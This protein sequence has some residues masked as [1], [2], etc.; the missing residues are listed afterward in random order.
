MTPQVLET[1]CEWRAEDVADPPPGPN[2]LSAAEI[3]EIEAAIA[4]AR[5]KSD[6]LLDIGKADFPAADLG[7]APEGHRARA[8]GRARLRADPRPAA[9]A[10]VQRRDVPGLLGHRRAP[11]PALA[12]EPQRPSAGRRHRPGQ[13]CRTIPPRAAT[14]SARSA[15]SS[16]ATAPTSS[17]CCAW[18]R[19]V[20]RRPV[21]GVPIRW[22][23][24][25]TWCASGRTWPPSST[26]PSPTTC[27]A[28][29][30]P[31]TRGWYELPVFTDLDGRLF[32]RLIGA[33]ILRLAAPRR[34]RRG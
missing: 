6:D 12:A 10:L 28:N 13:G 4:H 30:R 21:G 32:V 3:A 24:T 25:T 20:T 33:Y 34:T 9:R 8:D 31:G 27:A 23:C 22:P 5:A 11:G 1:A 2:M 19:G 18:R 15:W 17:A 26:S 7:P 29:R 14:S 16:T